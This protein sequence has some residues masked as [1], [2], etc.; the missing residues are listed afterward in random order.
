MFNAY[1]KLIIIDHGLL[2]CNQSSNIKLQF[3]T[4]TIN[5]ITWQQHIV[6]S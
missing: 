1:P 2:S 4:N 6:K 5:N 3:I